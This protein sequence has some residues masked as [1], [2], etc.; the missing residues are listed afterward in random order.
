MIV[1]TEAEWRY[2]SLDSTLQSWRQGDFAL[3]TFG[4]IT[5]FDPDFPLNPADQ[6]DVYESDHRPGT[7]GVCR[8]TRTEAGAFRIFR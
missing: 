6:A 5:R 2:E 1:P 4:F 3:N 8:S 7:K